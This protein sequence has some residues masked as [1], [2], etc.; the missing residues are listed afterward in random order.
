MC[1]WN[2][3]LTAMRGVV[4]CWSVALECASSWSPRAGISVSW[5]SQMR[6]VDNI[7]R[8][9]EKL[10]EILTVAIFSEVGKCNERSLVLSEEVKSC[11]YFMIIPFLYKLMKVFCK[12]TSAER[13]YSSRLKQIAS[14]K[15]PLSFT[16]SPICCPHT[17]RAFYSM[18]NFWLSSN[19]IS[20]L[21]DNYFRSWCKE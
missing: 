13:S 6:R 5:I 14:V 16:F 2:V 21:V 1:H 9:L 19:I 12:V 4:A 10:M 18:T 11:P 17:C 3:P 15:L 7:S 8:G 20:Y